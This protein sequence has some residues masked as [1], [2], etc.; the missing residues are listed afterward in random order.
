MRMALDGYEGATV[1]IQNRRAPGG[2]LISSV[3]NLRNADDI[4]LIA[5]SEE[6]LRD[7]INRLHEAGR[8]QRGA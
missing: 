6:E 7:M 1:Y 8:Q 4:V 3:T 2:A 5:S